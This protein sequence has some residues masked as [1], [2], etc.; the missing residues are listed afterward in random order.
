MILPLTKYLESN[1]VKIEYGIDVKN[2]IFES[3][4]NKKVA[5]Q[6]IYENNGQEKTID[7]IEDDLVFITNGCC[8]DTSCLEIKIVHQIYQK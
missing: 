3:K 8:T 5:T 1:G 2:V 7:L 4:Q 6:I